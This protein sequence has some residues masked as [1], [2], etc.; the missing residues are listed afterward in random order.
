MEEH[1][2]ASRSTFTGR[3]R[4]HVLVYFEEHRYVLNAISREKQI[5]GWRRERKIDLIESL[6]PRWTNLRTPDRPA[7]SSGPQDPSG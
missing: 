5:K 1:R 4:V 2:H 6:N 3:Y 7:D